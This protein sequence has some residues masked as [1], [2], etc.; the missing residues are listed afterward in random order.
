MLTIKLLPQEIK[1]LA[2]EELQQKLEEK[3]KLMA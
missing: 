1:Q 2:V 3:L